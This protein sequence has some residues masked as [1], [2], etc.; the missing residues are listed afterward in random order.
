MDGQ[1]SARGSHGARVDDPGSAFDASGM[2]VLRSAVEPELCARVR[3]SVSG[4][5]RHHP[6]YGEKLQDA[7]LR[8]RAVRE[9]ACHPRI[10]TGLAALY[11]RRPIPF[12]TLNFARGTEQPLHADSIHFD[13]V[14]AGWMC[15]AW[16]ALEEVGADQGPLT[17]VPGSQRVA[18][19]VFDEVVSRR[20]SGSSPFDMGTYEAAL[21]RRVASMG[22]EEFHASPGDVLIWHADLAHGGA[23]VLDQATTRW[24]Q[25]THYF[26]EGFTYV[27]PML[28]DSA[29]GEL[30]VREPLI[31]I[32][33][34]RVVSHR[35]DGHRAP[36][37]RLPNGRSVL[38]D[39]GRQDIHHRTRVASS[40]R[41][42]RRYAGAAPRM[43]A[44]LLTP[45]VRWAPR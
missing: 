4:W 16:V 44:A 14:P 3:G 33:R 1:R 42:M 15:G 32:A 38:S 30:H 37:I 6:R 10:M 24:S 40:L 18:S 22:I 31:D 9:L 34:R 35:V 19:E 39:A 7:W 20:A 27:T 8:H 26:F 41:G 11:G 29:A 45:G 21:A 5:A 12:Q 43:G 23:K 13:S 36:L 28:G 25:V 17:V 2:V